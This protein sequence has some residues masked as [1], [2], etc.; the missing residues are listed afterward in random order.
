MKAITEPN[1]PVVEIV[2][3]P[4]SGVVMV[5]TLMRDLVRLAID[6]KAK[7]VLIVFER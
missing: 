5:R 6:N 7:R 1:G 2:N 4:K 3:G